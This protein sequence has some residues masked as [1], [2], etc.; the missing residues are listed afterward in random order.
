MYVHNVKNNNY[1]WIILLLLAPP[2]GLFYVRNDVIWQ[3][4]EAS[5][6]TEEQSEA[7]RMFYVQQPTKQVR[8][9]YFQLKTYVNV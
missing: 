5:F 1:S 2:K 8:S 9:G 6:L 7:Q 4:W 3:F